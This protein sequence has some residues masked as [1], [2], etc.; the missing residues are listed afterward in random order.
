MYES[1]IGRGMGFRDYNQDIIGFVHM[2]PE[3]A[4][5]KILDLAS[6]QFE[7]GG[8]YHQYQPLTKRGNNDIGSNFNDD[9]LWLIISVTKYIKETGDFNILEKPVPYNNK[10]GTEVPL[11]EHLES[12]I[13]YTWDQRGPH[14]LPLIGRADWNDCLNLNAFSTDPDERF[15]TVSNK[16]GKIAESIFIAGLFIYA[17]KELIKLYEIYFKVDKTSLYK[18]YLQEMKNSLITYGWDGNWFLRAYDDF[19]NKIGSKDNIEGQI[20]I[21]TQGICLM[22]GLGEENKDYFKA[23]DSVESR[24]ATA[25][26]IILLDPPFTKYY[27]NLGEIS[28]YP[29]GLK[30]NGSIFCHTN[31]W[32]MIAETLRGNGDQALNYY[33]RI[34]PS[35][36]EYLSEIHRSEPYV[37]AQTIAGKHARNQGEAKNSWLTGTSAWTMEAIQNWILGIRPSYFGLEIS[38]VVPDHWNEFI[39]QRTFRKIKYV[40]KF[41]RI[42]KGNECRVI[43]DGE[44]LQSNI[45]PLPKNGIENLNVEV[46]I[47]ELSKIPLIEQSKVSISE[48]EDRL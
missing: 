43:V 36:R 16:D 47:G 24:L 25:H 20:F 10:K 4:K 7:N 46:E 2:I 1:G 30:E 37:Y 28:S 27:L 38:P 31:P 39:V 26:G 22:A 48:K 9:P 19:G 13:K 44:K 12:S 11:H 40:I 6:T 23:L 3:K 15:Q 5:E 41:R 45:I 18:K 42:G 29:P 17:L 35:A 14:G 8:A 34:N 32:I 33:L 21:E